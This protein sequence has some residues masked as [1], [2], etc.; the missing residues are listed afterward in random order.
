MIEDLPIGTY[1]LAETKAPFGYL[2]SPESTNIRVVL[3]E[4]DVGRVKDLGA[5]VNAQALGALTW[6]KIDG[7]AAKAL[8]DGSEWELVAFD[9]SG[10]T[11]VAAPVTIRDCV[12]APCAAGGDNDATGGRFRVTALP[13]GWY[14]LTETKAPLGF[15]LNRAPKYVQITA[16]GEE[17]VAGSFVNELG[18]GVMLPL[19]GGVGEQL[20]HLAGALL[21][22]A[23]AIAGAA[24]LNKRRRS[25]THREG[26]HHV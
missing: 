11:P 6:T 2:I 24:H 17:V 15:V 13:L 7:S 8:L 3:A 19:T 5:I 23:A 16:D 20:F 9:R 18:K 1:Q 10:G 22:V 25:T 4:G 21:G 26:N 12:S 14:R